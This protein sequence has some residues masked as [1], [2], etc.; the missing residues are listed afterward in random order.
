M[1]R[2]AFIIGDTF[3]YWN[4]IVLTLAAV[5][6]ICFFLAF[7]LGKSANAVGAAV[8]VPLALAASLVLARLVHWYSRSDSYA[9]FEAALTDYTS[10]GYALVGVFAGCLVA[11]ALLRLLYIVRDL[12]EILDC[13][14]IAG[15]AGI[16][17]GRLSC[18][19]TAADRG[20]IL[21]GVR[22]LPWVYPVTNVVSGAV[23]YRLATFLLQS[24]AAGVIFL[25]LT[26][27]FLIGH[28]RRKLKNGDVTLL[29]LLLYGASQAVL[30][31]TRYDS[32]FLR[33]NGFVSIVQILSAC[34]IVFA[35]VVF[36]VRMVKQRRFRLW[37]LPIWLGMAG[38][39]GGAGYME[40]YVQRHG[41]QAAFAYSIMSAA[42]AAVVL[43]V[44][45]TRA[46]G[47]KRRILT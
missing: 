41:N 13:A 36:S 33:S 8:M 11:A 2:I 22:E 45:I 9:G 34:A 29:F 1:D 30:D 38:G 32:L 23:E 35:A 4:S 7:Y 43:L 15:S 39:L 21:E 6:A 28:G 19:F 24:M 10:G 12:P 37:Q 3:V 17:V 5:T 47:A 46:L 26:A 20:Q 18:F 42:L 25:I 16:A 14:C 27:V 44:L 40:Y 31:S